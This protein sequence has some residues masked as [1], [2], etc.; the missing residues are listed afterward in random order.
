MDY[1]LSRLIPKAF[2]IDNE[3][4]SKAAHPHPYPLT[5]RERGLKNRPSLERRG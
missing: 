3:F 1:L 2:G 4:I 5:S